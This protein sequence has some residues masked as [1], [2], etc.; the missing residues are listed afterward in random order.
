L[1]HPLAWN[2]NNQSRDG[3]A[4]GRRSGLETVDFS[5]GE[6]TQEQQDVVSRRYFTGTFCRLYLGGSDEARHVL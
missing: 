3:D 6:V 4:L 1:L 5:E 2:G